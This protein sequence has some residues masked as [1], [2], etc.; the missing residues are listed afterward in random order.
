MTLAL[1]ALLAIQEDTYRALEKKVAEAPGIS[2]EI[3]AETL[4]KKGGREVKSSITGYLKVKP[5]NKC[6]YELKI[7]QGGG[8]TANQISRTDGKTTIITQDGAKG[9][10]GPA[11]AGATEFLRECV[12]RTG[13]TPLFVGASMTDEEVG[14]ALPKPDDAVALSD[15][16][17]PEKDVLQYKVK[18]FKKV[19]GAVKLWLKDGVPVKR[20]FTSTSDAAE[21]EITETYE[22][23]SLAEI[24]DKLFAHE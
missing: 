21:I 11:Q 20:V 13:L 22:K 17:S 3:K 9:R 4:V 5:G 7:D 6:L 19:E 18:L 2:Y 24:D 16:S 1:L 14:D 23:F 15:F 12:L 8:R 10:P